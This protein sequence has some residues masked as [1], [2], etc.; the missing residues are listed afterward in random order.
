MGP[1]QRCFNRTYV[2]QL[3]PNGFTFY[4]KSR[5]TQMLTT[6][7]EYIWLLTTNQDDPNKD[8]D[9]K[10][11]QN[12]STVFGIF[13][14][15]QNHA[16]RM[17]AETDYVHMHIAL[18]A[19]ALTL[20]IQLTQGDRV[21][22]SILNMATRFK[23]R[24]SRDQAAAASG[25]EG[26]R[27]MPLPMAAAGTIT[28]KM[29]DTACKERLKAVSL[30]EVAQVL[31]LDVFI[32]RFLDIQEHADNWISTI[33]LAQFV[34]HEQE[35]DGAWQE[36]MAMDI[37][38]CANP[39]G[40]DGQAITTASYNMFDNLVDTATE[41]LNVP[42]IPQPIPQAPQQIQ[43]TLLC[44][45]QAHNLEWLVPFLSAIGISYAERERMGL[46]SYDAGLAKIM[47][48]AC[49]AQHPY[50][51]EHFYQTLSDM[52][53]TCTGG[54]KNTTNMTRL[55]P[56]VL[57]DKFREAG[58][59][60]KVMKDELGRGSRARRMRQNLA[61]TWQAQ[62]TRELKKPGMRSR[63]HKQYQASVEETTHDLKRKRAMGK[64]GSCFFIKYCADVANMDR[65]LGY[66]S[67]CGQAEHP[68][69]VAVSSV[70][71]KSR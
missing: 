27:G 11:E 49:T 71:S 34:A 70:R 67:Y 63:D 20:F 32:H 9:S 7:E 46:N 30:S 60:E 23:L 33:A 14:G 61:H 15:Q 62:E 26:L 40:L 1:S 45:V 41:I 69:E 56:E 52:P 68:T 31:Q 2:C 28:Q 17:R 53:S 47:A 18:R 12:D 3:I 16:Q 36:D 57:N 38:E 4:G 10:F 43:Q 24:A 48:H 22:R 19:Y 51:V 8:T 54:W 21:H 59:W 5:A 65:L 13:Q 37:A 44:Y 39:H 66:P 6:G 29:I 50:M 42:T 64:L 35:T 58:F 55:T 25:P